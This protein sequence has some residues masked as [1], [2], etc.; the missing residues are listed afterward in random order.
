MSNLTPEQL[1]AAK[2]LMQQEANKKLGI[3]ASIKHVIL[4][5]CSVMVK[6]IDEVDGAID[7]VT[8][9]RLTAKIYTKQMHDEAELTA[10]KEL[11]ELNA[12]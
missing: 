6:G 3:F 9:V 5:L 2:I 10:T 11:K 8:D 1:Q 12:S 4:K 7:L